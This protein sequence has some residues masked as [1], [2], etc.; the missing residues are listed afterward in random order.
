MT[1]LRVGA[2]W[3]I[4]GFFSALI[5][6]PLVF[7]ATASFMR[8]IDIMKMPYNWIPR[9]FFFE[10]YIRAFAGNDNKY[11]YLRSNSPFTPETHHQ[12]KQSR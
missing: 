5:L 10:N 3:L 9:E 12:G 7:M 6:I 8:A 4:L 2:I 1:K 11:T